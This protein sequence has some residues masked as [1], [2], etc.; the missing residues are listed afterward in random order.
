MERSPKLV[1][2]AVVAMVNCDCAAALTETA[3]G[4]K[5]QVVLAGNPVQFKATGP[6][7]PFCGVRVIM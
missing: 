7:N 2:G 5:E 1:L 3:D 6:W 4:F